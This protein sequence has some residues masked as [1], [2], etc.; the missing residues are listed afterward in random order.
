MSDELTGFT[1]ATFQG[2]EG[3]SFRVA[4]ADADLVLRE[5]TVRDHS[6]RPGG[7]FSLFFVGPPEPSLPQA[8]YDMA[9]AG[10][11][12]FALFLV[13]LGRSDDGVQYEAAF[14]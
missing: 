14:N 2:H 9:H 6:A 5:V 7:G 13:P 4:A 10:L 1:P 12:E 3:E 11:G 8:T